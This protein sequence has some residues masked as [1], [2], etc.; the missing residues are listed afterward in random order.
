MPLLELIDIETHQGNFTLRVPHLSIEAGRLY[1]LHGKNGAGKSTLLRLLALLKEP[2][3]G[4]MSLA[5]EAIC[6]RKNQLK[7][8]RRQITLLEQTPMLF[9]DSVKKN[10]AFG[11]KLRGFSGSRLQRKID[12]A[13]AACRA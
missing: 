1:T 7:Q 10:L 8:L 11:L 12:Y 5:G 4:Q 2:T 9:T 6:W 3:K 13:L